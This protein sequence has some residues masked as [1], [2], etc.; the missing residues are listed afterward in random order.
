M[1]TSVTGGWR[2]GNSPN[3]G[4]RRARRRRSRRLAPSPRALPRSGAH[5]ITRTS[6]GRRK[7]DRRHRSRPDASQAPAHTPVPLERFVRE[8]GARAKDDPVAELREVTRTYGQGSTAVHAIPPTNGSF[9]GDRFYAVTGPSGSGKTTLLNLLGGLSLATSGDVVLLGQRLS[10]LDREERATLRRDRV[11]IIGQHSPL[12]TIFQRPRE[13]GARSGLEGAGGF[14]V[15]AG[16]RGPRCPG[17][18]R[19]GR[20]SLI[21]P[22]ERRAGA[23]RHR[24]R[25][26]RPAGSPA[27][28]TSRPHGSTRRT[29]S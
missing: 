1:P 21:P 17:S 29:R 18:T 20:S 22:L 7:A 2:L 8:V 13:R 12:R 4:A 10:K 28:S 26:R 14:A 15:G 27:R 19:P 25:N 3:R 11:A 5:R 23:R 9:A 6:H 16:N 24:S